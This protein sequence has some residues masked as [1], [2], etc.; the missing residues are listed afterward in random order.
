M[1][2]VVGLARR[3]WSSNWYESRR[4]G[5]AGG[6]NEI[7]QWSVNRDEEMAIARGR[8]YA[9]RGW[10]YTPLRPKYVFRGPLC[11]IDYRC[12]SYL[13]DWGP[14]FPR[15][16]G[17]IFCSLLVLSRAQPLSLS[18]SLPSRTEQV[19]IVCIVRILPMILAI[20][21]NSARVER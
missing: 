18:F 1:F 9:M 15:Q 16:A 3:S 20:I 8:V 19:Q 7:A 12:P 17:A 11:G 6:N 2:N 13:V 21:L 5:L 4:T 10:H 14:Q